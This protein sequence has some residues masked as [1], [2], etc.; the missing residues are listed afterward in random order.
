MLADFLKY[1]FNNPTIK[2]MM[3]IPLVCA[4]VAQIYK[5]YGGARKLISRT[6]TQ[7]YTALCRSLLRR[8]LA[9][10]SLLS[11]DERMPIDFKDLPQAVY[12]NLCTL[13]KLHM[14]VYCLKHWCS[15]DMSYLRALSTWAL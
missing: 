9:E 15:T 7:L 8:Y 1:I 10:N 4:I 2:T 13:S 6:M 14:M 12:E 11:S 3:Y 5:E